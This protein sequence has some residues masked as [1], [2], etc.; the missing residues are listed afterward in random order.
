MPISNLHSGGETEAKK[1]RLFYWNPGDFYEE[2]NQSNVV[3]KMGEGVRWVRKTF[4]MK[5]DKMGRSQKPGVMRDV[6]RVFIEEGTARSKSRRQKWGWC[7][8]GRHRLPGGWRSRIREQH[9]ARMD[10][11]GAQRGQVYSECSGKSWR[12]VTKRVW[13]D[14]VYIF[15]RLF[16]IQGKNEL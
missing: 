14:L 9:G 13:Q 16:R 1:S 11:I 7:V 2:N 3:R 6:E 8:W 10:D 4:L 15:K 5:K 12:A